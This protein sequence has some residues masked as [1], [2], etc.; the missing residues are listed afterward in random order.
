MKGA[1]ATLLIGIAFA[2]PAA[3]AQMSSEYTE[4]RS[5]SDCSVFEINEEGGDF[6]QMI[7]P[8]WKGYPVILSTGDL[9]ESLFYGFPPAGK[10]LVWESFGPFNSTGPKI[11]WRIET[12]GQK[13]VPIATIHRWF[14]SDPEDSAKKTEVLVVEKVGQ[15]GIGD[16]C[17]VGLVVATGNPQAN[18]TARRI[19]DETARDFSCGADERVLVGGSVPLPAFDRQEN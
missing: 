17:T 18:E 14:V 7:C 5:D 13:A 16:G 2:A 10:D 9:R 6:A 11:E 19:A 4:I 1:A 15:L 12:D 8:G 3:A